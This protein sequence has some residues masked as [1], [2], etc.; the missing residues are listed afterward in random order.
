MPA[1]LL[2]NAICLRN[3]PDMTLHEVVWPI[4]LLSP[5]RLA[6]EDVIE[7]PLHLGENATKSGCKTIFRT[8]YFTGRVS[9]QNIKTQKQQD[10]SHFTQ[11]AKA[12][13][14]PIYPERGEQFFE[15]DE[16][17]VTL[18]KIRQRHCQI[19]PSR[20]PEQHVTSFEGTT[21]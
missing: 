17:V 1:D 16:Q 20:L 9:H 5:Q 2:A 18:G 14:R 8:P 21:V 10:Q 11:N 19:G 6:G 12:N 3:W 15:H 7:N 4:G 13:E